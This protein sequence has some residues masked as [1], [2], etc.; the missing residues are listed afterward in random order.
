MAPRL[1]LFLLE[2][3]TRYCK[4]VICETKKNSDFTIKKSKK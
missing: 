3:F 2:K 4:N 1:D